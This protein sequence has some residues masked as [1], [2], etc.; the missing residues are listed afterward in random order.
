M[1][2]GFECDVSCRQ[3]DGHVHGR[4]PRGKRRLGELH[5]D[6]CRRPSRGD[7]VSAGVSIP[8]T[9]RRIVTLPVA[10]I[11]TGNATLASGLPKTIPILA[12]GRSIDIPIVVNVPS[13]V[14]R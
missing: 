6:G 14:L 11:E 4:R 7:A 10:N 3:Y 2:S 12:P 13:T 9:G 1:S 5:G 8:A